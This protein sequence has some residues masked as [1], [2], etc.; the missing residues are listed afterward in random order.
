MAPRAEDARCGV[1]LRDDGAAALMQDDD[2]RVVGLKATG[3]NNRT[4]RLMAGAVILA[5]GGFEGNP[6][7]VAHYLGE[8]GRY[9]RPVAR[10]GYYNKGEG[11]RMSA[12]YRRVP[13][14]RLQRV[15]CAA[16]RP[17]VRR[18]RTAGDDLYPGHSGEP[19]RRALHR[20]GAGLGRRATTRRSPARSAS[21][22]AGWPGASSTR[23]STTSRIGSAAS[24][25]TSRRSRHRRWMRWRPR[26]ALPASGAAGYGGCLQC[27]LHRG[28]DRSV[29][30]G[31]PGDP[32][33][34]AAEVQLGRADCPA[35]VQGLSD[36]LLEYIHLRRIEGDRRRAGSEHQRRDHPRPLR[37]GGDRWACITASYPG[38]TSVLRGAVFGR[39][40]PDCMQGGRTQRRER[41]V[42]SV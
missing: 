42:A 17:A 5:C 30:G 31:R 12:R 13:G 19:R 18:D 26:S 36:H 23:R 32:R 22:R 21:S 8:S 7:M 28:H 11:I 38:A 25:P 40:S 14:R 37:G 9:M 24:G 35:A 15:P 4:I 1:F 3:K 33:F 16:D 39:R 27:A 20:R 34:G 2:G 41:T 10:G 29:Y 6:E